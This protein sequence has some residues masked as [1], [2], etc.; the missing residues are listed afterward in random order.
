LRASSSFLLTI[1]IILEKACYHIARITVITDTCTI[2][3]S[4][5]AR[6]QTLQLSHRRRIGALRQGSII[7]DGL[8]FAF[9]PK[10][11]SLA[12][13]SSSLKPIWLE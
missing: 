11:A 10:V 3:F 2:T 6:A 5:L 1:T 12:T 13:C 8:A 9:T 7:T 4:H